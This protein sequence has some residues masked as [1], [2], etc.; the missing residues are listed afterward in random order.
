MRLLIAIIIALTCSARAENGVW[1]YSEGV[2][3]YGKLYLPK[4]FS[5]ESKIPAVVLAPGRAETA[6][7]I[8]PY[9]AYFAERGLVAMIIDYRGWGKSGGYVELVDDVKTD[10]RL[11]FSQMTAKV[12]IHRKRLL[13]QQ[14]ILDIRNAVYF[15]QGEPGVDRNRI[16]I[17]GTDMSGGHAIVIAATDARVK[18]IV[19]QAPYLA[20]K[21]TPRRAQSYTADLL[22]A[23]QRRARTGHIPGPTETKMAEAEYHPFWYV[24]QIPEKTAVL[25]VT[26]EKEGVSSTES[27]E[28]VKLLKGPSSIVRVPATTAV[29]LRSGAA[30]EKSAAA[31]ADWFLKHL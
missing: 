18:A 22:V 2:R 24:D 15:L 31:A 11:R 8:E 17:W 4:D 13:P 5:K 12:R 14:Q 23:E 7:T 26:N 27:S 21:D 19:A 20:G 6:M 10:D 30:F 25:I 28:A 29:Q 9:A 16:G 3:C 1:F